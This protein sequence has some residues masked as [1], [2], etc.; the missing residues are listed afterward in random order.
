VKHIVK[1]NEA[2]QEDDAHRAAENKDYFFNDST[3]THKMPPL[4]KDSSRDI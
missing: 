2:A 3:L 1:E 4:L